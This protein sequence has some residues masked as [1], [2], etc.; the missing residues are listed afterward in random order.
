MAPSVQHP[1]HHGGDHRLGFV[2][3]IEFDQEARDME[4]HGVLGNPENQ[5]K[6]H[7]RSS[8]PGSSVASRSAGG[9]ADHPTSQA[10]S[11]AD[12]EL[13]GSAFGVGLDGARP[14]TQLGRDFRDRV[15]HQ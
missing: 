5:L 13:D 14:D 4:I 12:T 2:G 1:E 15:A 7:Q 8:R 3:D 10:V 6:S 9:H 11:A